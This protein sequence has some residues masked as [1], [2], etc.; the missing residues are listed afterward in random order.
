MLKSGLK[1]NLNQLLNL[2]ARST[3]YMTLIAQIVGEPSL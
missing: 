1:P 3:V 2:Y